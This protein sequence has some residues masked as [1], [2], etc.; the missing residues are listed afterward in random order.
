MLASVLARRGEH[1]ASVGIVSIGR[2]LFGR[3]DR[4]RE[5]PIVSF[6]AEIVEFGQS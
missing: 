2:L 5:K 4:D 3:I 1:G 6:I